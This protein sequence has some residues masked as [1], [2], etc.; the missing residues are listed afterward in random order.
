[1]KYGLIGYPISHSKSPELFRAAYPDNPELTYDLIEE[2]DFEKAFRRFLDEYDAV[3]V[4]A[5][6]KADAFHKVTV[7]DTISRELFAVNI[8]KKKDGKIYGFNSDFWAL[9]QLLKPYAGTPRPN[10]LVIGCGGAAKAAALAALKL[11]MSVRVANRDFRKA[12]EFC[13]TGGGMIPLRMEQVPG[14]LSSAQILIYAL[15]V[16]IDLVDTMQLAGKV[17]VEANYKDPCLKERCSE[18]GATYIS[19]MDWLAGQAIEGYQL[20]TGLQPDAERV[21]ACCALK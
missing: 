9:Q 20:M 21:K 13:F 7:A 15:P 8:L 4:T 1:M 3:N 16:K 12:R 10:V 5:P 6:F 18:A 2:D 19:G 17:V 11:K 14:Q